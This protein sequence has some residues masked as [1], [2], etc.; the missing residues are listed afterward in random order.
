MALFQGLT[1]DEMEWLKAQFDN[2]CLA[3]ALIMEPMLKSGHL[4]H[5]WPALKDMLKTV[6]ELPSIDYRPT[7]AIIARST[8]LLKS[9]FPSAKEQDL[10]RLLSKTSIATL[11]LVL[12]SYCLAK[13]FYSPPTK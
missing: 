13:E 2:H 3:E 10:H 7:P 11:N 1:V 4:D 6:K 9:W 8:K 5:H 12:R